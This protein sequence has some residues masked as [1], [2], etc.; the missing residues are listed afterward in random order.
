MQINAIDQAQRVLELHFVF[1][2]SLVVIVQV[3]REKKEALAALKS[4]SL[5]PKHHLETS[6]IIEQLV[7]SS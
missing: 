6:E 5:L 3:I 1:D 4:V 2:K 7:E